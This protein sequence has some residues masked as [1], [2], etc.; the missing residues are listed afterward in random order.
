MRRGGGDTSLVCYNVYKM[1]A[2]VLD[3]SE[4]MSEAASNKVFIGGDFNAHHHRLESPSVRAIERES[5]SYKHLTKCQESDSSIMESPPIGMEEDSTY[6]SSQKSS[7]KGPPGRSIQHW[8]ETT[9][10]FKQ[11]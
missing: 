8:P 4:L 5:T 6:L 9:S 10:R 7:A 1:H 11:V 3:I 2:G